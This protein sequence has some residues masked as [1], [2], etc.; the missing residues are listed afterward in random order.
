MPMSHDIARGWTGGAGNEDSPG[1]SL[2]GH[3]P[4]APPDHDHQ[5]GSKVTYLDAAG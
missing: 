5:L 2:A 3:P 4:T 1:L